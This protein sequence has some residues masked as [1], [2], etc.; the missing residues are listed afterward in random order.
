LSDSFELLGLDPTALLS[1]ERLDAALRAKVASLGAEDSSEQRQSLNQ[2]KAELQRSVTRCRL[3]LA[4]RGWSTTGAGSGKDV[5]LRVFS[6]R[7]SLA[8]AR[9]QRDVEGVRCVATSTKE[10]HDEL[11][12]KFETLWVSDAPDAPREALTLLD[13]LTYLSRVLDEAHAAED[14]LEP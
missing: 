13:E 5:L 10:R 12:G 4:R 14:A 7:E 6:L 11:L 3:L 8:E 1:R 9:G 2:A